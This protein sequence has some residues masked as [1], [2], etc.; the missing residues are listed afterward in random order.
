MVGY[1]GEPP[2]GPRPPEALEDRVRTLTRLTAVLAALALA[3]VALA[4]VAILTDDG[5]DASA[6]RVARIDRRVDRLE[7]RLG[8][9]EGQV[10]AADVQRMLRNKADA[11]ELRRVEQD[12]ADLRTDLDRVDSDASSTA[13]AVD[14]LERRVDD[15][16]QSVQ[17]LQGGTQP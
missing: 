10:A 14:A 16:D 12:V 3:G 5:G 11:S 7:Q 15:I 4:L 2:T 8:S 17:D 6:R 13:R 1:P 9:T